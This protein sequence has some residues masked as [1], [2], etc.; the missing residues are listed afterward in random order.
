MTELLFE[1][2]K[3]AKAPWWVF[4]LAF[5]VAVFVALLRIKA[6]GL[7]SQ[8]SVAEYL[9][10]KDVTASAVAKEDVAQI[11]LYARIKAA[12]LKIAGID[13]ALK[14][15]ADN[16]VEAKKRIAAAKSLRDLQG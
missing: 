4:V 9:R 10:Y 8:R 5:V 16:A 15:I 1:Q 7:R 14:E 6:A 2:L 12:D 11:Q 3:K 13:E